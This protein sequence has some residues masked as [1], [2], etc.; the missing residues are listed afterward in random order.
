M[1]LFAVTRSD[2][3]ECGSPDG[4]SW[5]DPEGWNGIDSRYDSCGPAAS[6]ESNL[7][8]LLYIVGT[9]RRTPRSGAFLVTGGYHGPRS[10]EMLEEIKSLEVP[11]TPQ[12]DQLGHLRHPI[13]DWSIFGDDFPITLWL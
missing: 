5:K 8:I 9:C 4:S 1:E 7:K 2:L 12:P 11:Q 13:F 3:E 10:N 6:N